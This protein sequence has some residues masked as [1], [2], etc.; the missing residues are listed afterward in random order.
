MASSEERI[1]EFVAD[2]LGYAEQTFRMA[3]AL[4]NHV[5]PPWRWPGYYKR[6]RAIEE[7]LGNLSAPAG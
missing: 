3:E 5:F 2:P 4:Q 7:R 1:P 6:R